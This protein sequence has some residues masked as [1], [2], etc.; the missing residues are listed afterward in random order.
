MAVDITADQSGW[1]GRSPAQPLFAI[2]SILALVP[3]SVSGAGVSTTSDTATI[4]F[5][6]LKTI[7]GFVVQ[8]R[9]ISTGEIGH[10]TDNNVTV[11]VSGNTMTIVEVAAG[12]IE[13]NVY[14]GFVW[15][16]LA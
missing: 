3:F 14:S 7:R 12:D 1:D 15:G 13:V 8:P 10:A 6:S 2:G 5:P 9:T 16:D 11:T 4:I